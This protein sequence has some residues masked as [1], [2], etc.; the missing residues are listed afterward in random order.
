MSLTSCSSNIPQA[1]DINA[2]FNFQQAFSDLNNN[3]NQTN[4]T[5]ASLKQTNEQ[6]VFENKLMKEKLEKINN[7]NSSN[8]IAISDVKRIQDEMKSFEISL[9]TNIENIGQNVCKVPSAV[10]EIKKVSSLFDNTKQRGNIGEIHLEMIISSILPKEMYKMQPTLPNNL[11][12]DCII[13]INEEEYYI[14]AK[15]PK[16]NY[17]KLIESIEK[18]QSTDKEYQK[19]FEN[20]LSAMIEDLKKY[21]KTLFMFIPSDKIYFDILEYA[22]SE[23]EKANKSDIILTCPAMLWLQLKVLLENDKKALFAKQVDEKYKKWN[24]L[25]L[26]NFIEWTKQWNDFTRKWDGL[27]KQIRTISTKS[28]KV[29]DSAKETT[30][31]NNEK[32]MLENCK[33]EIKDAKSEITTLIQEDEEN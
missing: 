8:N 29:I 16:D 9:K 2:G 26:K 14:D 11:K 12:P 27:T 5:I 19:K 17:I 13:T 3:L 20:D 15:F 18:K 10:D 4:L 31:D 28:S 32:K 1:Q 22:K 6:L 25:I 24:E 7:D 21:G 23:V 33:K 30:D